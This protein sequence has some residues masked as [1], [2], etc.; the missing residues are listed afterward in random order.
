SSSAA[1]GDRGAGR[2]SR[3]AATE[4]RSVLGPGP[5]ASLLSGGSQR[6]T[7]TGA[8]DSCRTGYSGRSFETG[9]LA[10]ISD[11]FS[12]SIAESDEGIGDSSPVAWEAGRSRGGTEPTTDPGADP[13]TMGPGLPVASGAGPEGLDGPGSCCRCAADSN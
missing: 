4:G 2:V 8:A 12:R 6:P 3:P 10:C 1:S 7:G 11:W 5:P 13:E 9:R